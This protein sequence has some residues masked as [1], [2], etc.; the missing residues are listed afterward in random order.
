[1]QN[2]DDEDVYLRALQLVSMIFGSNQK[3]ADLTEHLHKLN[4]G[5]CFA[6]KV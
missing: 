3:A 5:D 2:D 1:M 6:D 4:L